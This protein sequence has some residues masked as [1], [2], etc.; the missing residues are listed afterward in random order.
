M[1]RNYNK[2][3]SGG[4]HFSGLFFNLHDFAGRNINF[5]TFHYSVFK[6]EV[7]MILEILLL[8][9]NVGTYA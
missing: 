3:T 7:R 9:E 1:C 4:V 6:M 8:L 2:K 5:S